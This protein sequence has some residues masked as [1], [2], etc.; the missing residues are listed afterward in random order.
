M[1]SPT[2]GVLVIETNLLRKDLHWARTD[3]YSTR[4]KLKNSTDKIKD[5]ERHLAECSLWNI[6]FHIQGIW[7]GVPM[8]YPNSNVPILAQ[9]KAKLHEKTA[10]IRERFSYFSNKWSTTWVNVWVQKKWSQGPQN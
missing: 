8:S 1:Q 10:K 5:L 3:L 6:S 9:E 2:Q 7:M 4:E